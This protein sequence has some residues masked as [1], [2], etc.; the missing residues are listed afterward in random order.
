ME[1]SFVDRLRYYRESL[2]LKKREFAEKLNVTES[3]YN[4]IE[5]GKRTP[6]KAFL[7][8]LVVYSSKPEEYWLYGITKK[9]YV[10]SRKI[11][12]DT[13]LAMEQIIKLGLIKDL[14]SLFEENS[15]NSTAEE[16]LK[17]AVK[18]DLSYFF[19]KSN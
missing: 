11:T 1:N 13:E 6:S 4:L 18:A 2:N 15:T 16:L 19:E 3:Y 9:E 14:N 8:K 12:K 5:N 7:Y 17:A 10:E